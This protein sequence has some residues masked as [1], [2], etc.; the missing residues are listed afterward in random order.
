[1]CG[2]TGFIAPR[3]DLK[4]TDLDRLV[5]AMTGELETLRQDN[6]GLRRENQALLRSRTQIEAN[7]ATRVKRELL[8]RE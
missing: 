3:P 1:M 8:G 2:V 7:V 4:T 5:A 6:A